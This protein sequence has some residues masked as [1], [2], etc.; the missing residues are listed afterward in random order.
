M[1]TPL[2][3]HVPQTEPF[4]WDGIEELAYNQIPGSPFQ[5]VTR[6]VLFDAEHGLGVQVR[7]FEIAP[8]GHST[9]EHHGHPHL[10]IPIRGSGRVLVQDRVIRP[11]LNDLIY[12]P[13]WAWHQLRADP[14][15]PFGFLCLVT[16]ERDRPVLPGPAEIAELERDPAVAEFIRY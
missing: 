1:T 4:R 15:Q 8:G 16:V 9:L 6:R 11:Q 5:D 10:V 3:T 2:P 12:V 7:Y 14:D 13:G